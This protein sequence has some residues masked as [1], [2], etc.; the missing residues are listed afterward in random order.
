M[1]RKIFF[2][3]VQPDEKYFHWQ[4]EVYI[5]NFI[6]LGINPKLIHPI[7]SYVDEPS[8]DLIK[9]SKKYFFN[10]VNCNFSATMILTNKS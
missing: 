2:I 6:R 7:F 1:N 5:H 8:E 3:S 4:V 10:S 9:L